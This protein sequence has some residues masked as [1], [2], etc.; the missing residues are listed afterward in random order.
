[1]ARIPDPFEVFREAVNR[2]EAGANALANRK[3]TNSQ[4]LAMSLTKL[5][6]T[7][8][9]LQRVLEKALA[10]VFARL[11]I[12][13]RTELHALTVVVQRVED[14]LDLLLGAT[15]KPV[16]TRRPARTRQPAPAAPAVAAKASAG[17][18]ARR[19]HKGA[20]R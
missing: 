4:Q 16:A 1:M 3:L 5:A 10:A 14:K 17:S 15:L 19:A 20:A 13:S 12:P 8:M 9:G 18:T 7:S 2:F 6:T 11:D